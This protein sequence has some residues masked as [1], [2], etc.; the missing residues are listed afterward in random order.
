MMNPRSISKTNWPWPPPGH[1]TSGAVRRG[2]CNHE[3]PGLP[4]PAFRRVNAERGDG[5]MVATVSEFLTVGS[6]HTRVRNSKRLILTGSLRFCKEEPAVRK[7]LTAATSYP[8]FR[9]VNAEPGGDKPS[10]YGDT[11]CGHW[12]P[13]KHSLCPLE[14]QRGDLIEPRPAAWVQRPQPFQPR[15]LKGRSTQPTGPSDRDVNGV[16]KVK[17]GNG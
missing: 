11:P 17:G 16:R 2:E 13:G 8:A 10:P 9:R 1:T 6:S 7:A 14:P 4:Y 15:A 3:M 5:E 12:R